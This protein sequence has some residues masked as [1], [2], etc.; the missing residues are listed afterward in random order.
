MQSAA[1]SNA[2]TRAVNED[3]ISLGSVV[4][5]RDTQIAG[6]HV[7]PALTQTAENRD[8]GEPAAASDD[9]VYPS[10]GPFLVIYTGLLLAT[11]VIGFDSKLRGNHHPRDY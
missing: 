4:N 10:R 11:F 8:D 9:T 7:Q 3:D 2:T 5:A 1:A 6:Q